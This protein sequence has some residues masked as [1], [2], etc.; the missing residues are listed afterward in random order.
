MAQPLLRARAKSSSARFRAVTS[1]MMVR[2]RSSSPRRTSA[3]E[4][5]TATRWPSPR[6]QVAVVAPPAALDLEAEA[7][8][9]D[10]L[11]LL[12]DHQ[13]VIAVPDDLLARATEKHFGLTVGLDDHKVRIEEQDR[14]VRVLHETAVA[15]LGSRTAREATGRGR[16]SG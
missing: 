8:S 1:R 12:G 7:A 2:Y 10:V 6:E 4:T 14:V 11:T 5:S 16:W 15:G 9:R 13:F 3:L